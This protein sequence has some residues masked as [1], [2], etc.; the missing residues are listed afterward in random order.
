MINIKQIFTWWHKQSLGT[1]FKTLFF[2]KL[3]GKDKYGNK[4]Y[5]NRKDQ[6]WVVYADNIEAT[7]ITSQWY[8]WMHHTT[9]EIP[10][11]ESKRFN[12]QKDHQENLTG[13]VN[14]YKPNKINKSDNKKRYE[15]WKK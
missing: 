1:F 3:V 13:T 10:S 7:K 2:G 6:R 14:S 11:N 9:N 5:K 8:L 4:Y 15:S 12:W